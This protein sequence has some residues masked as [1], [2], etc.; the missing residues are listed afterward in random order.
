MTKVGMLFEKE[1]EE[2]VEIATQQVTQQVTEMKDKEIA[3]LQKII[4]DLQSQISELE[5]KAD[6]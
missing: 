4:H 6:S 2:A 3:E 5:K 1:K